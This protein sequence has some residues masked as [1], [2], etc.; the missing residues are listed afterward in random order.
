MDTITTLAKTFDFAIASH[1]E[2]CVEDQLETFNNSV[3]TSDYTALYSKLHNYIEDILSEYSYKEIE[4]MKPFDGVW[5]TIHDNIDWGNFVEC[6]D[7]VI[8]G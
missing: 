6:S 8:I 5:E 2:F 4:E 1:I 7:R 3:D